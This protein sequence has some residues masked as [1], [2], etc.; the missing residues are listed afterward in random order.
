M[1]RS[2]N[3]VLWEQ[4]RKRLQPRESSDGTV[5][6]F[7]RREGVS[8]AAFYQWR[9]KLRTGSASETGEAGRR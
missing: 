6:E 4:W 5:A 8:Q 3:P 7:C 9:K 2:I 1:A